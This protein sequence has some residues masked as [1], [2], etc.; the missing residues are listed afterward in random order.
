MGPQRWVWQDATQFLDYTSK[1]GSNLLNSPLITL[2]T[3]NKWQGH[4]PD[5]YRLKWAHIWDKDIVDK[6][7][8]FIL[9]IWHQVVAVNK[10]HAKIP[11]NNF[12]QRTYCL[13]STKETL[14]HRFWD[15]I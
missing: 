5:T 14:Q 1:I 6:E 9:C 3:L 12:A 8:A 2:V 13:F 15:C 4:L 10:W 11:A 7:A